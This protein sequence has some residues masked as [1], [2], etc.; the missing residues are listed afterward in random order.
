MLEKKKEVTR[1]TTQDEIKKVRKM[2]LT[3]AQEQAVLDEWTKEPVVVKDK[4]FSNFIGKTIGS[5]I[6]PAMVAVLVI[7]LFFSEQF[8]L[9]TK[10]EGLVVVLTWL[11]FIIIVPLV[12]IITSVV[13]L[14][15]KVNPLGQQVMT[16]YYKKS[17]I[18]QK[19]YGNTIM[20]ALVVFIAM[21]NHIA[22]TIFLLCGWL[23]AKI[24]SGMIKA[25][26]KSSIE[27]ITKEKPV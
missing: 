18:L 3:P 13:I 27:K 24:S 1:E 23:I 15:E 19:I 7:V 21:T 17:S 25:E 2:V 10:F 16:F 6:I 14:G 5:L 20:I 11:V 12:S 9:V 8:E 22:T 4:S 26:I